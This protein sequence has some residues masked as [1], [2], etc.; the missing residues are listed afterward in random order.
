MRDERGE[1][2]T[3]TGAGTPNGRPWPSQTISAG[4][5]KSNAVAEHERDPRA[6]P[7]MPSVTMNGG[8]APLVMRKPL[9]APV[10]APAARQPR[11]PIHQGSR[12]WT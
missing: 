3:I 6:T 9:T 2:R 10:A 12:D 11:M 5:H 8:M 7:S 1:S 4:G